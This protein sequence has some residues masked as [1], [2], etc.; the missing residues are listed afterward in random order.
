MC[1]LSL[2]NRL[3]DPHL[4]LLDVHANLFVCEEALILTPSQHF[5]LLHSVLNDLPST[6][7]FFELHL[8]DV[9]LLLFELPL[10]LRLNL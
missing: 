1:Y 4:L 9:F 6:F 5:L 7:L 3:F 2:L 10:L 8:I